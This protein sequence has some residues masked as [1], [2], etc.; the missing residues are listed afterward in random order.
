V[1]TGLEVLN[2]TGI[3]NYKREI[4]CY[5]NNYVIYTGHWIGS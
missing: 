3:N 4:L 1:V 2:L 5:R